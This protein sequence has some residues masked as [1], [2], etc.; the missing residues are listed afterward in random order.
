MLVF[1]TSMCIAL[2]CA[3]LTALLKL[4]IDEG[5][6]PALSANGHN[7]ILEDNSCWSGFV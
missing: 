3:A 2:P 4:C 7:S 1:L 6:L 5:Y